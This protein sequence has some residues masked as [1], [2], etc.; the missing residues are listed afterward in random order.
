METRNIIIDVL[1]YLGLCMLIMILTQVFTGK[2]YFA[3]EAIKESHW[4]LIGAMF[5]PILGKLL[6]KSIDQFIDNKQLTE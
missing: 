4:W 1:C 5:S 2:I 3:H 6:Y